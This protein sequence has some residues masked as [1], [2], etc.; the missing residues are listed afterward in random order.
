MN[1]LLNE[2]LLVPLSGYQGDLE[3]PR[4]GCQPWELSR[5]L[6]GHQGDPAGLRRGCHPWGA[7][8]TPL[9]PLWRPRRP[10]KWVSALKSYLCPSQAIRAIWR[11]LEVGVSPG[12]LPRPLSG[13]Q[14]DLEGPRRG[15]QPWG[16]TQGPLRPSR[17]PERPALKVGSSPGQLLRPLSGHQGDLEGP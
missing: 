9:R 8:Q 17:R 15:F 14:G 11:A 13:H 12:E 7:S 2:E 4:S 3:G 10:L 1:V 6:S 16:A 5:P